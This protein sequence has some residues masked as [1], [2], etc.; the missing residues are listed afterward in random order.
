MLVSSMV[1]DEIWQ[2]NKQAQADKIIFFLEL[3]I[4]YLKF[5]INTRQNFTQIRNFLW[6][7]AGF[8]RIK[9]FFFF[10]QR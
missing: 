8:D 4:F 9:F 10:S 2:T 1:Q 7:I 3:N 6:P 5:F